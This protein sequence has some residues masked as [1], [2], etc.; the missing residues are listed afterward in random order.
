MNLLIRIK[1]L[2]GFL[3]ARARRFSS[4]Q[5]HRIQPSDPYPKRRV[6][7]K[8]K[9]KPTYLNDNMV[10]KNTPTT[11]KVGAPRVTVA[12]GSSLLA[13]LLVSLGF[14]L[15]NGLAD[16]GKHGFRINH[17]EREE[18]KI[19]TSLGLGEGWEGE[20]HTA[21]LDES[22]ERPTLAGD[23][24]LATLQG[25]AHGRMDGGFVCRVHC[26]ENILIQ[27][28]P[29]ALVGLVGVPVGLLVVA[30]AVSSGEVLMQ[31]A[32]VKHEGSKNLVNNAGLLQ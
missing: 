11:K 28:H 27:K 20:G 15:R 13:G 16:L 6:Q 30:G 26:G 21:G 32:S 18:R 23:E 5:I 10:G 2:F 19:R 9:N 1:P 22:G 4:P 12:K 24:N 31:L 7:R 17:Q 29:G 3:Q 25:S 8:Q 14:F